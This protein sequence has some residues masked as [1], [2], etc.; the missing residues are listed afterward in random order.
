MPATRCGLFTF[1]LA[2]TIGLASSADETAPEARQINRAAGSQRGR[3]L[4]DGRG[5]PW[6]QDAHSAVQLAKGANICSSDP[7][8][9]VTTRTHDNRT[10]LQLTDIGPLPLVARFLSKKQVVARL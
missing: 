4:L 7:R 2:A 6:L 9:Q 8:Y 10:T 1:T 3:Q 5:R